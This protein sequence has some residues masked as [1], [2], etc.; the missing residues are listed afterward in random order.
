[1]SSAMELALDFTV[2]TFVMIAPHASVS[3][4]ESMPFPNLTHLHDND[5]ARGATAQEARRRHT[6][7]RTVS[8]N[9]YYLVLLICLPMTEYSVV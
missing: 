2:P 8:A 3:V 6:Y 1:M 5:R 7:C 4:T 9:H